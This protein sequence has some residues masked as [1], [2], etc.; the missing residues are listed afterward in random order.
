M[1]QSPPKNTDVITI[2]KPCDIGAGWLRYETERKRD[3][4]PAPPSHHQQP[5][6]TTDSRRHEP[7]VTG[8][9]PGNMKSTAGPRANGFRRDQQK[10]SPLD[11]TGQ[12][13]RSCLS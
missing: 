2:S 4:K 1:N 11:L 13:Q 12:H 10:E 5:P 3:H 9:P 6:S 7:R 8:G